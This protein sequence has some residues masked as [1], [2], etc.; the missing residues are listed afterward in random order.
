MSH[1]IV[2]TEYLE[3]NSFREMLQIK[4]WA[5]SE[6]KVKTAIVYNYSEKLHFLCEDFCKDFYKDYAILWAKLNYGIISY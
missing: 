3:Q 2:F 6:T 4:D 5:G 1:S